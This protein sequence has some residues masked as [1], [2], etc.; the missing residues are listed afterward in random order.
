MMARLP[1]A[2]GTERQM[3]ST[4]VT[5]V[6]VTYVVAITASMGRLSYD[7]WAPLW[8]VPLVFFG[9]WLLVGRLHPS[10]TTGS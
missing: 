3:L 8:I 5:V 2:A 4:A 6:V 7:V 1:S 9:S 10:T